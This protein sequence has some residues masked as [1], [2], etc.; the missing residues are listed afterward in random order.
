VTLTKEPAG[1]YKL[2]IPAGR[3]VVE[4]IKAD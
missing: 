4:L 1:S 3:T 2:G